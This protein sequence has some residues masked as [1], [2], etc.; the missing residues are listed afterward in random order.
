MIV[1]DFWLCPKSHLTDHDATYDIR[2]VQA[3]LLCDVGIDMRMVLK[4]Q[5]VF[6]SSSSY[7]LIIII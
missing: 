4:Y 5:F 3:Q 6:K 7:I 2:R 1:A